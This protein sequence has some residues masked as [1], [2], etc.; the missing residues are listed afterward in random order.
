MK[1]KPELGVGQA[2][3]LRSVE[4]EDDEFQADDEENQ[5][6]LAGTPKC[7]ETES[8]VDRGFGPNLER[9]S[10]CLRGHRINGIG[11]QRCGV[12]DFIGHTALEA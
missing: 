5:N 1:T 4:T 6:N 11:Y 9:D 2:G 12:R 8:E 3:E 7:G 10:G